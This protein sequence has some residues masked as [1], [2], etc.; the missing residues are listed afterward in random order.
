MLVNATIVSSSD[1]T[2]TCD[3]KERRDALALY[4]PVSE[5]DIADDTCDVIVKF[6][7]TGVETPL[8]MFIPEPLPIYNK[9]V[10]NRL[11]RPEQSF[12]HSEELYINYA[13]F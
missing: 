6:D 7:V 12:S 8:G 11:P 2:S 9:V 10:S 3:R 4:A 5:S 1:C 13:N